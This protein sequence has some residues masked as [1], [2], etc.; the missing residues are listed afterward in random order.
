MTLLLHDDSHL[1]LCGTTGL[2][3][4]ASD[5]DLLL[6]VGCA[7][8]FLNLENSGILLSS[9]FTF[10]KLLDARLETVDGFKVKAH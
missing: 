5:C 8:R 3:F 2:P 6:D 1:G 7:P 9:E 10:T 4:V